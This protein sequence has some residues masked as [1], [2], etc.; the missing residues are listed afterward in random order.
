MDVNI[1][2]YDE[3]CNQHRRACPA[4][5]SLAR[6]ASGF[7]TL[8]RARLTEADILHHEDA[9]IDACQDV[10]ARGGIEALEN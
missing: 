10:H 3:A 1:E 6:P 9:R 2:P 5:A 4:A 7:A 8:R